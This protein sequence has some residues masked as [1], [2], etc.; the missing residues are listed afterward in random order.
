[1]SKWQDF[2][3]APKDDCNIDTILAYLKGHGVFTCRYRNDYDD[4]LHDGKNGWYWFDEHGTA[5][6]G[7]FVPTHWMPM[8]DGPDKSDDSPSTSRLYDAWAAVAHQH[9]DLVLRAKGR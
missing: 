9:T 6:R 5:L 7:E 2:S 1:M 8:P 3:T 4:T